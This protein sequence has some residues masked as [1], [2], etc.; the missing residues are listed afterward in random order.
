MSSKL[1]LLST[2]I[3]T[4]RLLLLP[5]DYTHIEEIFHN[6]NAE[7]TR[8]MF[9][10]P[11]SKIEETKAFIE[12][13]LKELAE[14]TALQLQILADK[15]NE[16]IG[17]AGIHKINSLHPELGIWIKKS[18]HGNAYGLEAI[19]GMINWAKQNI[20]FEYL[21]YPVD[22]RNAASRRIP[23]RNGGVIGRELKTINQVGF[24]L[25][26]VEYWIYR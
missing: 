5:I 17:C 6:F 1:N 22:K 10:K 19:T 3:K 24:E 12:S 23:E 8:Y 20:E 26:E 2:T 13:S 7:I 18:T 21:I 16:F 25:D 14:G 15:S 9:P 4:S 11:A